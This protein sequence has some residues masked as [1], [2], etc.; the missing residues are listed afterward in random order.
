[1]CNFLPDMKVE[2][3]EN[4]WIGSI[5]RAPSGLVRVWVARG[6]SL[7]VLFDISLLDTTQ[8]EGPSMPHT[9]EHHNEGGP[10]GR[11]P[12]VHTCTNR[13]NT[14]DSGQDD[15]DEK[16]PH[17]CRLAK[18]YWDGVATATPYAREDLWRFTDGATCPHWVT[19][20]GVSRLSL[21][22]TRRSSS[23]CG[24]RSMTI[25]TNS[26]TWREKWEGRLAMDICR[27]VG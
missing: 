17:Q 4:W 1:M 21:A 8:R 19:L 2:G 15:Q 25:E 14:V 13:W 9:M 12:Y 7:S 20:A 24:P 16:K 6:I 26:R 23:I 5:S 3:R 11:T 10:S 18:M 22:G 27:V